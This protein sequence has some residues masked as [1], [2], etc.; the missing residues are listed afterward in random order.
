M[1]SQ[2]ITLVFTVSDQLASDV[3]AIGSEGGINYW[4]SS[5]DSIERTTKHD[6]VAIYGLRCDDPAPGFASK[7]N[8]TLDTIGLGIKR[9]L[10]G[11]ADI[12]HDIVADVHRALVEDDASYIDAND[13]DAIIQMGVFGELVYS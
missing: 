11:N 6:Y 9:I 4:A 8:V 2:Q 10:A 12:D 13:A 1:A 7:I 3:M 5:A